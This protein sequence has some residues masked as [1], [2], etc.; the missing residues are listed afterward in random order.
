MLT[1][2]SNDPRALTIFLIYW[3]VGGLLA[4]KQLFDYEEVTWHRDLSEL[5]NY[6]LKLKRVLDE[7]N[8]FIKL[9]YAFSALSSSMLKREMPPSCDLDYFR[10]GMFEDL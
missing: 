10:E 3:E 2:Y 8:F 7:Q 6:S 9:F 1:A 5:S 4:P